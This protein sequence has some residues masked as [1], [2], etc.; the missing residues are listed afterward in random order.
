M[1]HPTDMTVRVSSTSVRGNASLVAQDVLMGVLHKNELVQERL[2][3]P[4]PHWSHGF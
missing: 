4:C 2:L 1:R 3:P